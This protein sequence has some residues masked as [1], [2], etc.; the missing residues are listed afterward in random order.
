LTWSCKEL[1]YKKC[2]QK[3]KVNGKS[4]DWCMEILFAVLEAL[5]CE[6]RTFLI[7]RR[8]IKFKLFKNL[9]VNKS[10]CPI[11]TKLI[12]YHSATICRSYDR[13]KIRQKPAL[14]TLVFG[15]F[16]AGRRT[17]ADRV[18]YINFEK[19]RLFLSDDFRFF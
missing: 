5:L 18:F 6:L 3:R 9:T 19:S 4:L 17:R 1:L 7:I 13:P 15:G 14:R 12:G 8:K 16:L 2:L 10:I 11:C